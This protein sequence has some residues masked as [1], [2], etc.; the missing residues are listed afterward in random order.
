MK[1]NIAKGIMDY[2]EEVGVKHI[3]GIP[4][5]NTSKLY[6]ALY[7]SKIEPIVTKHESAATFSAAAYSRATDFK[8]L[9]VAIVCGGVGITNA[10]N[11]VADAYVNQLPMLVISGATSTK[12][13]GRGAVQEL[14]AIPIMDSITKY[15]VEI[16]K[17]ENMMK[18]LKEAIETAMTKPYGPVHLAIPMDMPIE[19]CEY[20]SYKEP[21]NEVIG[22]ENIELEISNINHRLEK[23]KKGMILVG[24][25]ASNLKEEIDTISEKLGWYVATTPQGKSNVN[26]SNPYYIG[27]FGFY[28]SDFASKLIQDEDL[29]TILVLGSSLGESATQNFDSNFFDNKRIIHI[30]HERKILSRSYTDLKYSVCCDIE[31]LVKE[32]SKSIVENEDKVEKIIDKSKLFN[33][34]TT[35]IEGISVRK[36]MEKLPSVMSEDTNYICDIGEFMNYAFKYL[37]LPDQSKFVTSLNY[38][39]MGSAL[40]S[41]PGIALAD[42]NRT[43]AV[44]VGDGSY[45]MNG[46]EVLSAKEKNLPIVYFVLN[47]AKFNYVDQGLNFLFGRGIEENRFSRVDISKISEDMGIKSYQIKDLSELDKIKGDLSN[48]EGPV[49]VEL[50]TE[51]KETAG[52]ADRFKTLNKNMKK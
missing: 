40:C 52:N 49:V 46:M 34:A 21:K 37:I 8:E 13:K 14:D 20:I 31:I 3:F 36:F 42:L 1:K 16:D 23:A 9:G 26:H 51:G 25:G 33:A 17:P 12:S 35:N 39:S 50:I 28:S 38:G 48:L 24:R 30:D 41:A 18:Y 45:Y 15:N 47:N 6:D 4:S 29:D 2:L 19:E 5:G 27:N 22:F 11:G 7:E 10:I 32:L 44:I 43:T